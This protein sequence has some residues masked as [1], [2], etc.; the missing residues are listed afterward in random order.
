MI[1]DGTIESQTATQSTVSLSTVKLQ[2]TPDGSELDD[3]SPEPDSALLSKMRG[4]I[5]SK[6]SVPPTTTTQTEASSEAPVPPVDE[7]W[8][9]DA[10]AAAMLHLDMAAGS[11]A[12]S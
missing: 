8:D 5:L 7:I 10:L 4:E 3:T 12:F 6:E 11:D 2:E 1:V 9:Q